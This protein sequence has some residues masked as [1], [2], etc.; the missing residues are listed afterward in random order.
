MN[1]GQ[2]YFCNNT[3]DLAKVH[4]KHL[5]PPKHVLVCPK[6]VKQMAEKPKG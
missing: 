1:V 3:K 5:R 6:H 4:M 2:C